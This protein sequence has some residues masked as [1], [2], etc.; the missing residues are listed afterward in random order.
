MKDVIHSFIFI[1]YYFCLQ[2][3]ATMKD[4][5]HSHAWVSLSNHSFIHSFIHFYMILFLST[6]RGHNERRHSCHSS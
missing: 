2:E 5:I 4:V 3:E 6:G 1:R